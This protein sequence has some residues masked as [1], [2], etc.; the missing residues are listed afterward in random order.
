MKK[1]LKF[2]VV[3]EKDK[4][5]GYVA[6]CPTLPGCYSQGE[7]ISSY[8]SSCSSVNVKIICQ[9]FSPVKASIRPSV[10]E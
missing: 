4:T 10:R 7:T 8:S 9:T 5:G 1:I 3:L 6:S 2:P